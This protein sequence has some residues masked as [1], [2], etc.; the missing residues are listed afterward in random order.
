MVISVVLGFE[1]CLAGGFIRM[2]PSSVSNFPLFRFLC[3]SASR[4]PSCTLSY[5]LLTVLMLLLFFLK[6]KKR[7]ESGTPLQ[8]MKLN[9][10]QYMQE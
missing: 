7:K 2:F 1:G 3:L 8:Q 5:F 6:K 9:V 10:F 4:F